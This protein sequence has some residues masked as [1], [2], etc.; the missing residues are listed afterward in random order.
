[1]I[2]MV[3]SQDF[4]ERVLKH[5][6]LYSDT[7]GDRG[8]QT[9]RGVTWGLYQQWA[10]TR[11]VVPTKNHFQ[12]LNAEDVRKIYDDMFI[13]PLRIDQIN[14]SLV[15][16]AFFGAAILHGGPRA[17]RMAQRTAGG[18]KVDGII[19]PRSISAFNNAPPV[20]FANEMAVRRVLFADRL[21]QRTVFKG[22]LTQVKFIFGWHRRM[23]RFI[24]PVINNPTV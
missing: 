6:G 16:E 24:N 15:Q 7:K 2:L 3:A 17:S 23:L 13:Q 4:V 9:M 10:E 19:G 22:D 20:A 12:A 1:M 18:L 14:S 21:V 5:E 11:H 8:G